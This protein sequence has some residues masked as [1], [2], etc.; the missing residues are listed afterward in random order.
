MVWTA[1][2][3][4]VEYNE[5]VYRCAILLKKDGEDVGEATIEIEDSLSFEDVVERIKDKLRER[6]QAESLGVKLNQYIDQEIKL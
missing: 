6:V 3:K 4:K 1:I 5:P 2:L